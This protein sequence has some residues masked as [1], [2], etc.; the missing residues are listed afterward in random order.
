MGVLLVATGAVA[1]WNSKVALPVMRGLEGYFTFDTDVARFG[2]NRA[3]GKLDAIVT[4]APL[5]FPTHG[6]FNGQSNFLTTKIQ[7]TVEQTIIVVGKSAAAVPSGGAQA[8]QPFYVSNNYGSAVNPPYT[9]QVAT[10]VTLSHPDNNRLSASGARDNGS[11]A[12]TSGSVSLTATPSNSWAIRAARVASGGVNT[13]MDLTVNTSA[14]GANANAR[15]INDKMFRIGGAA[16][17]NSALVDISAVAIYSVALTDAEIQL[18]AG[19]M[20]KRMARLGIVV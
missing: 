12:P 16:L 1:P 10:G 18:V 7:E 6:R 19:V 5:A 8:D 4:G 2:F 15:V 17:N 3:P 20:R 9:G 14:A 11:G 13:A